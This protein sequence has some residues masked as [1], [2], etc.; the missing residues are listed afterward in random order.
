MVMDMDSRVLVS[1][2]SLAIVVVCE[3]SGFAKLTGE[4]VWFYFCQL[5][6]CLAIG[7]WRSVSSARHSPNTS[8]SQVTNLLVYNPYFFFFSVRKFSD[9]YYIILYP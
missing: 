3:I 9:I 6:F 1:S 7:E 5:K 2:N 8:F 4:S